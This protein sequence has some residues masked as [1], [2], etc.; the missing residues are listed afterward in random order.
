MTGLE[1]QCSRVVWA[2]NGK[3]GFQFTT[4]LHPA[5]LELIVAVARKPIPKRV[6]KLAEAFYGRAKALQEA[7]S[8]LPE[9]L[10]LST[11]VER[12]VFEGAE[13]DAEALAGYLVV[14]RDALSRLPVEQL[15]AGDVTWE[16]GR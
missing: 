1:P 12:T 9:T 5:T 10:P 15:L 4:P 7:F 3:M 11:V 2:E 14:T 6:K 13:G 8:A 16:T